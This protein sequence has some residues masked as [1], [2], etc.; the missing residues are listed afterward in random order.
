LLLQLIRHIQSL[1]ILLPCCHPF[2]VPH[3]PFSLLCCLTVPLLFSVNLL[4]QLMRH[5]QSLGILLGVVRAAAAA[6][7]QQ[8]ELLRK[9]SLEGVLSIVLD[10]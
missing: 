3:T 9:E 6:Q 8:L 7:G 1:G 4:L 5:I 2:A 10:V